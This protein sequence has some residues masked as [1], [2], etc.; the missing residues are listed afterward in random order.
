[1]NN[2]L[3]NYN[4][5]K[6]KALNGPFLICMAVVFFA[7]MGICV[8]SLPGIPFYEIIF[9]RS[10][11]S[12]IF[13]ALTLLQ[14]RT[15]LLGNPKNRVLLISRG[16]FGTI[17]LCCFFFCIKQLNFAYAIT[18]HQMSPLFTML[19]STLIWKRRLN[20][21]YWVTAFI[22]FFGVYWIYHSHVDK[23]DWY[24]SVGIA[25]AFFGGL[26]YQFIHL[27]KGKE[28]PAVVIF[29]FPLVCVPVTGVMLCYRWVA[30]TLM[31][32]VILFGVGITTHIAQLF[33]TMAYQKEEPGKLAIY[34]HLN[35][36]LACILS[37][38][39]FDEKMTN[40]QFIGL[41]IIVAGIV[42][43]SVAQSKSRNN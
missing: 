7:L 28:S 1:M 20:V 24:I 39:L 13:C 15:P 38:L 23:F 40:D 11:I 18:L 29:Y 32:W 16:V 5:F 35:I 14:Q 33:L 3:A 30:P 31:E 42:L 25:G 9:F 6:S 19:F 37:Y 21:L 22:A 8:K 26:A 10:I 4:Y 27:L 36:V 12:A 34:S 2:S 17:G 41:A 43:S